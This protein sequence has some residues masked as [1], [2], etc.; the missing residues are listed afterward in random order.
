MRLPRDRPAVP[1]RLAELRRRRFRQALARFV[2]GEALRQLAAHQERDGE[3]DAGAAVVGIERQ[4]AAEAA[5]GFV[6]A[7]EI[8]QAERQVEE[9]LAVVAVERDRMEVMLHRLV[10][11]VGGAQRIAEIGM[12]RGI[13]GIGRE[14]QPVMRDR[15]VELAGQPSATPRL[16]CS[17]A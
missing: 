10:E 12:Q 5:D 14:R 4:R 6:E 1:R 11:L 3:L 17:S 16:L 2:G 15:G 9:A 7:A 13:V 8:A